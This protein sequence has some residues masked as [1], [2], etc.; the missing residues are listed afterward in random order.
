M[1]SE[2]NE[3]IY[4]ARSEATNGSILEL[5]IAVLIC[6]VLF[7]NS[8]EWESA[9]WNKL[10]VFSVCAIAALG[11]VRYMKKSGAESGLRVKN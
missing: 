9:L 5:I 3:D 4:K 10:R 2:I 11:V 6:F 1:L 8:Y 7:T